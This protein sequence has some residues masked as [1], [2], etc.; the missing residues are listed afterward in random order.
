MPKNK[1]NNNV[2]VLCCAKGAASYLRKV[3]QYSMS[4]I[5]TGNNHKL[6]SKFGY[7]C[8]IKS[9]HK[10]PDHITRVRVCI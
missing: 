3:L 9:E 5:A 4:R 8:F 6:H 7:K 10:I 2:F 1:N